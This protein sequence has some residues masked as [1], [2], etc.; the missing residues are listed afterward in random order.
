MS[1]YA[2]NF[3]PNREYSNLFN[4]GAFPSKSF[5]DTTSLS[6]ENSYLLTFPDCK[7]G[8]FSSLSF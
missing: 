3:L 7:E 5:S 8:N 4:V 1:V 2:F 6:D